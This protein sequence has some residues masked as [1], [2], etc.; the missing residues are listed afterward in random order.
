[1]E[2]SREN[3]YLY[4]E[5]AEWITLVP[6]YQLLARRKYCNDN[7]INLSNIDIISFINLSNIYLKMM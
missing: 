3:F 6:V 2:G 5:F 1:M 7:L 4:F